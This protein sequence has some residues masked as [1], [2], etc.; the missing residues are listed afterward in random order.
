VDQADKNKTNQTLKRVK[1]ERHSPSHLP[2]LHYLLSLSAQSFKLQS[3]K[4]HSHYQI[5]VV[6]QFLKGLKPLYAFF[7]VTNISTA[8]IGEF[9]EK[10]SNKIFLKN[11]VFFCQRYANEG[12]LTGPPQIVQLTGKGIERQLARN[13]NVSIGI[14][15]AGFAGHLNS[16]NFELTPSSSIFRIVSLPEARLAWVLEC[17]FARGFIAHWR[18]SIP[19]GVR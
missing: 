3:R 4:A 19:I 2:I 5:R 14:I 8:I 6:R 15:G 11:V 16:F 17:A 13:N 12:F 9:C 10:Y 1:G 18:T 7:P